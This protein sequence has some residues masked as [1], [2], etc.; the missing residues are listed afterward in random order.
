M[1]EEEWKENFRMSRA[2]FFNLV[3]M[4]RPFIEKQVTVMRIPVLPETQV[5]ITLYYFSDEGRLR[6]VAN[7]FG[8]S[9][10]YCSIAIR[11][12]SAAI[13]THLGP[14]YIKLPMTEASV[15]EKVSGFYNAFS[16]PQCLG[17]IDGTHIEIKRPVLNS[18]D[19][20][21]RKSRYTLNVQALCDYRCCFMDV[22]VK[23]PGSVHDARM[24]ANS[25]LNFLLKNEQIPPCRCKILDEELLVYIIGDP[26]YPFLMKEYAGG[27][28]TCQ[29]QYF[30][31][32]LCSAR[33]VIKCSFGRLKARFGCLRRAMDIN[34]D[35]LPNVIYACFVLHNFCEMNGETIGENNVQS[36]IAYDRDF[37]PATAT[38]RYTTDSN[39]TEV[40]RV[41]RLLTNY[42]D[43]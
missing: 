23:W 3:S 15:K 41:R 7:A 27:G 39:E 1:L 18:T 10:S 2:S 8:L 5:A 40:K 32:K 6:K 26:A 20:I 17:A 9:R 21:N 4:L 35:D 34:L 38:N 33:N 36:T 30:G 19:F 11:R 37:Q 43:P 29:E 13:T 14:V 22:V 16:V 12:V 28:T 24:L 25:R 31:Y 42:F